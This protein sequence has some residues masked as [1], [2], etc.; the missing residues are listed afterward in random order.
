MAEL[1]LKRRM[2]DWL[3]GRKARQFH[4]DATEY[5]VEHAVSVVRRGYGGDLSTDTH[6]DKPL[7]VFVRD[8]AGRIRGGATG[9]LLRRWLVTE[10]LWVE[11]GL[12][13]NGIGAR[14]LA[15]LE[16]LALK[17]GVFRFRLQT[18]DPDA[19]E[20][21]KR[22]GYEV[23]AWLPDDPPGYKNYSMSKVIDL[24]GGP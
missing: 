15:Q 4:F 6:R 19:L 22:N 3:T 21:F 10:S 13:G 9:F 14:A 18:T 8:E 1:K 7:G 16:R 2:S 12:R 11:E 20:F 24:S 23:Y 5:P 17:N